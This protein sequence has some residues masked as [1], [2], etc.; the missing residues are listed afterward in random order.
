MLSYFNGNAE[1]FTSAFH[2]FATSRTAGRFKRRNSY[3][4][5]AR[6]HDRPVDQCKEIDKDVGDNPPGPSAPSSSVYAHL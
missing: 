6:K 1:P 4:S 2:S 5:P 3:S